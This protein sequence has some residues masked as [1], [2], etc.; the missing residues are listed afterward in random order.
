MFKSKILTISLLCAAVC[1]LAQTQLPNANFEQWT[2]TEAGNA[3]PKYWHSFADADCQLKGIYAWGCPCMLKNHSN[4]VAGHTG[5]GC[6]IHSAFI[7]GVVLVNGVMTTGQMQFATPDTK[8]E[9]NHN[10]TDRNN[11]VGHKAAIPFTGRPDSVSF[12]CKFV[13]KK[14]SNVAMAKFHL[15]GDV[16]YRDV[17]THQAGTPQ[18]GK[19][20]NAFCEMR[21]PNDQMWHQ[22]KY[23]FTYYNDQNQKV[24]TAAHPNYILVTFSTNKITKGGDKGDKL[25]V[26][27]IVMIYNKRLAEIRIGGEALPE[28]NSE[29][30]NYD[31]ACSDLR[32]LPEVTAAAQS[33]NATVRVE[34]PARNNGYTARIIVTHDDGEWIYT[35]RFLPFP[36]KCV[37]LPLHCYKEFTIDATDHGNQQTRSSAI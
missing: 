29:T 25:V 9:N 35:V 24:G 15:H 19:V 3:M 14:P 17:S 12:W 20:G 18:K 33:P 16:A 2:T 11:T 8:S 28:F 1:G 31:F 5:Y 4:R 23:K 37:S 36:K 26:D 13:M 7:G 22:Y 30:R 27:D 6:E 10:Y 21:D 32:H 34:Q